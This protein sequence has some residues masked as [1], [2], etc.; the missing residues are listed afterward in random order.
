MTTIAT[1]VKANATTLTTACGITV[2]STSK[3]VVGQFDKVINLINKLPEGEFVIEANKIKGVFKA[4]KENSKDCTTF[5]FVLACNGWGLEPKGGNSWVISRPEGDIILINGSYTE[6]T[7]PE[8][9][10]MEVENDFNF[11]SIIYNQFISCTK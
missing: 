7:Q 11:N 3:G 2:T 1:I 6:T 9:V 4:L 5:S 8:E 10:E